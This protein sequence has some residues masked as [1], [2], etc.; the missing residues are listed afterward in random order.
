MQTNLADEKYI[1]QDF[2]GNES[3]MSLSDI[4]TA[5]SDSQQSTLKYYC[6]T[7]SGQWLPIQHLIK[8]QIER[9]KYYKQIEQEHKSLVSS[10]TWAEKERFF[11]LRGRI[12]P[13][14]FLSR[15]IM[16]VGLLLISSDGK[17]FNSLIFFVWI[18]WAIQ[19]VKRCHD[20][21]KSGWWS[22][23]YASFSIFSILL[24]FKEGTPGNN[25][26]GPIPEETH[27]KKFIIP[28]CVLLLGMLAWYDQHTKINEL[29]AESIRKRQTEMQKQAEFNRQMAEFNKIA[30]E[31]E[32]LT[33][34][35]NKTLTQWSQKT[36]ESVK[37]KDDFI[38]TITKISGNQIQQLLRDAQSG[39]AIA[40]CSLGNCYANGYGVE[41][42]ITE[43]A[44]WF[45]KSAE[46][47]YS[48]AEFNLGLCYANG[49]GVERNP[50]VAVT[51]FEKAAG[52]GFIEAQHNLGMCYSK[53]DGIQRNPAEAAKWFERAAAQGCTAAQ[54]NLGM[55]YAN[56]DGTRKDF[57]E[58]VKWFTKAAERGE[59]KAQNNLGLCY[60]NGDGVIKDEA[61]ALAWFYL[62]SANGV[63]VAN[64]IAVAEQRLG[65]Q[66]SAH[67]RQRAKELQT[68]IE[69]KKNTMPQN[70]PANDYK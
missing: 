43:A 30:T 70:A 7:S 36:D 38:D 40:Q 44:K 56:G 9:E 12:D 21:D 37:K 31:S 11:S 35:I 53:G 15:T 48:R 45:R 25:R 58:A 19:V 17:G 5:N 69:M 66:L 32:I 60:A 4:L 2:N 42:D 55:C 27:A 14:K 49:D 20:C 3:E 22:S 54:N 67:S 41:K 18:L 6:D 68:S 46:Q 34:K 47:G 1:V 61:E 28:I 52:H 29:K 51:W 8:K 63:D 23:L 26:F 59:G 16:C 57:A 13:Q 33:D 65:P 39:Q 62:S 24:V 50:T 64:N 10:K